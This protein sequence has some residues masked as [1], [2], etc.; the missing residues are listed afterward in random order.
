VNETIIFSLQQEQIPP[1][2]VV[3]VMR[4]IVFIGPSMKTYEVTDMMQK[5]LVDYIKHRFESRII[6]HRCNTDI[7][8]KRASVQGNGKKPLMEKTNSKQLLSK[9]LDG[10][11]GFIK[12]YSPADSGQ[13]AVI[14][15]RKQ[16]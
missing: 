11:I 8:S 9:Y 12:H 16:C 6:I 3:P 5:A 1:Y 13:S 14:R 10:L 15:V 7:G 4:P 2:D